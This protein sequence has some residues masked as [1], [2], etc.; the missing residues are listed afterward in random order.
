MN[1]IRADRINRKK[2]MVIGLY[3]LSAMV[4]QMKDIPQKTM[5][6][7][8][9]KYMPARFWLLDL[10]AQDLLSSDNQFV[11]C[12]IVRRMSVKASVPRKM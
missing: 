3:C 10:M 7:T 6:K 4:V 11:W 1:R 9:T 8:A 2:M 12:L 5:D